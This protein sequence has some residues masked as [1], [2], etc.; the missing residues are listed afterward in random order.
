MLS[1]Q[2]TADGH[3]VKVVTE[4]LSNSEVSRHKY[5]IHRRPSIK[6]F[7]MLCKW[8]DVILLTDLQPRRL[9]QVL[10]SRTAFIVQHNHD[11]LAEIGTNSKVRK[12]LKIALARI[13]PGIAVSDYLKA[14]TWSRTIIHNPYD[15]SVFTNTTSWHERPDDLAFVGRLFGYKGAH[16]IIDAVSHLAQRGLK[17][18]ATLIGEGPEKGRL[19]TLAQELGVADR[20]TFAGNLTPR[21]VAR[22]LNRHKIL[23]VPSIQPEG[24]GL[25]ALEGLAAGCAVIASDIGGLSEAVGP[26]GRLIAPNDSELLANEITLLLSYEAIRPPELIGVE[27]HLDALN[28][29]NVA[30]KYIAE[31][32]SLRCKK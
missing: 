17:S 5:E 24:F 7:R 10:L 32:N 29:R 12:L 2:F 28:L 30:K 16:V 15:E 22:T 6:E 27:E 3:D 18:H 4:T 25:V 19:Q 13:F 9:W 21:E 26:H 11:Y 23:V 31:F 1:C 8:A 20:I 14:K